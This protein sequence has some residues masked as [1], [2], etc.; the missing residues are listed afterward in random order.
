MG[1]S[2]LRACSGRRLH[3][4]KWV[5]GGF[6][7]LLVRVQMGF[8]AVQEVVGTVANGVRATKEGDLQRCEGGRGAL[9]TKMLTPQTDAGNCPRKY[10]AQKFRVQPL[11]GVS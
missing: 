5:S 1:A 11:Q 10:A 7:R 4:C 6:G 9:V 2:V 8:R 3:G